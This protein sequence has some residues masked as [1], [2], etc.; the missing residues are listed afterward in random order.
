MTT[1]P[2]ITEQTINT[3]VQ[4]HDKVWQDRAPTT[5]GEAVS[6]HRAAVRAGLEAALAHMQSA[7]TTPV[8]AHQWSVRYRDGF[9]DGGRFTEDGARQRAAESGGEVVY[10]AVGP[11]VVAP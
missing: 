5:Q 3:Y 10:R 11:W 9:V 2:P 8:V 4:A 1:K 7:D 6:T